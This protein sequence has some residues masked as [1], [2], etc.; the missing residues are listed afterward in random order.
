MHY[1]QAREMWTPTSNVLPFPKRTAA[2]A[3]VNEDTAG[4]MLSG[5]TDRELEV[6]IQ[7]LHN[8]H[9]LKR[10]AYTAVASAFARAL[11]E[12]VKRRERG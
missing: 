4:Q 12:Q 2:C 7:A 11:N 8:E 1:K 6:H 10:A 9:N 3:Q 5:L